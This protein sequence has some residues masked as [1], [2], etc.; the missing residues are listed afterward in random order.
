MASNAASSAALAPDLSRFTA[1][2]PLAARRNARL[3][4]V[5]GGD[6]FTSASVG[7]SERGTDPGGSDPSSASVRSGMRIAPSGASRPRA[8]PQVGHAGMSRG[9][10]PCLRERSR[11]GSF[12]FFTAHPPGPVSARCNRTTG[13]PYREGVSGGYPP[14]R[15]RPPARADTCEEPGPSGPG[16]WW[17]CAT[18]PAVTYMQACVNL[19]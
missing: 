18:P 4:V 15:P 16:S 17:T 10:L 9:A 11:G 3:S 1:A 8:C 14:P 6:S 7:A 12:A 13:G 2:D 5:V 19:G